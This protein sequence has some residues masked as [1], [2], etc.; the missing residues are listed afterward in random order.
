MLKNMDVLLVWSRKF[1]TVN[2]MALIGVSVR[3]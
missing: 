3:D 2:V 1:E